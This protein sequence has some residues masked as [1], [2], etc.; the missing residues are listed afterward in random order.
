MDYKI[1]K[2]QTKLHNINYDQSHPSYL[3][4]MQ[5]YNYYLTGGGTERRTRRTR[6]TKSITYLF[7]NF[8]KKMTRRNP[9]YMHNMNNNAQQITDDF[10]N[11]IQKIN[12]YRQQRSIQPIELLSDDQVERLIVL[13]KEFLEKRKEMQERQQLQ[14]R[15]SGSPRSPRSSRSS[16]SPPRPRSPRPQRPSPPP[17][18]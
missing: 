9:N 18:I 7:N 13:Y 11:F 8:L 3:I 14:Q 17:M 4:Y 2:Y 5:K 15:Q 1:E 6:K 10:N 12:I 16:R